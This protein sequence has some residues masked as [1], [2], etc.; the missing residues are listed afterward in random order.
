MGA[1]APGTGED[2][3]VTGPCTV[4]AGT[5]QYRN[6]NIYGGGSLTFD[7]AVIDFWAYGI[8][9]ENEG[10]L[11]AG[12]DTAPIGMMGGKLTIHLYGEAQVVGGSGVLCK[13]DVRC[14]VPLTIWDSN[15]SS[16][17]ML[18]G[19]VEDYFYQYKPLPEDDGDP[20][21]YFGYKVLG[22]SYGG[23]LRMFGKKGSTLPPR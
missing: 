13:S 9:V 5:Y 18:P 20:N 8:I 14:G 1:I 23:T 21:A 17:Q 22:V 10:S 2:L 6:V 19:G 3:V 7:D 15:G 16:P 11:I 12:E 4:G